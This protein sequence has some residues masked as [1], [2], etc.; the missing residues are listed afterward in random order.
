MHWL[1]SL[2]FKVTTNNPR[3]CMRCVVFYFEIFDQFVSFGTQCAV[4]TTSARQ[5]NPAYFFATTVLARAVIAIIQKP[6]GND[7]KHHEITTTIHKPPRNDGNQQKA[8]NG[9]QNFLCITFGHSKI[10]TFLTH[11]SP[12]HQSEVCPRQTQVWFVTVSKFG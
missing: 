8:K 9:C 2:F 4:V 1:Q 10:C 6:P 7:N 5:G 3:G 11:P 12:P